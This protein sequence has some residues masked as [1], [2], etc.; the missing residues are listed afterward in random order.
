M[1][2]AAL[3]MTGVLGIAV[4]AAQV[5]ASP[6]ASAAGGLRYQRGYSVQQGWLCYGWSNG[7]YHCTHHWHRSGG[8]LVSD[9]PAWV[10]NA[11][12]AT[13]AAAGRGAPAPSAQA[14]ANTSGEP[15]RSSQ[16]FSGAISQWK[17]PPSCYAG[18]YS[19]NPAKYVYRPSF[20]WCNWWPEVMNPGRPNLLWGGY[21]RGAAPRAGAT[22]VF[23]PGVQGASSA[24]HY[25]R[26]VAVAPG[27]YWMLVSEMN[28]WWRGGGFARVS[29][30]YIHTG[31]GISFI[32]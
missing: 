15:C 1:A 12:R 9:N 29:Y 28:F 5:S 13:T 6:T 22:V 23:A 25:A 16:F 20:G 19:I 17:T 27:G 4:I 10:P 30:R 7:A 32:Y 18:I 3:A 11:G 24:G 26:V 21:P 14:S 8:T 2:R 31:P